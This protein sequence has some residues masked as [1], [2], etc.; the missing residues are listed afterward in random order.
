MKENNL[1]I[2]FMGTP[3]FS[4]PILNGLIENYNVTLVVCQP[5]R[6]KNRKGEIIMPETKKIA[7]EHNIEV[8]QPE[9]I[10][11]DYQKILDKN[12]DIIITCA[13]G[14]IIP[15]IIINTPKYGAINV[16]GS[17]LPKLRG[18]APIHWAIING[19][20][21]TG[22]TIMKM[23]K[24]MDAGEI[25]SQKSL[26]I[27]EDETLDSLYERMSIL[28]NDL[29]QETIPDIINNK[30]KYTPQDE[31]KVT[32]GLNITKEDEKIDF[33][34]SKEEIKNLIRG[35][36]SNPGAYC[37]LDN[38]RL[39]IYEVSLIDKEVNNNYQN[40]QII[41]IEKDS[42]ICKCQ[43]GYLK[44]LDIALEGK[45][46]C[47]VKEYLNGIKKESLIGKVLK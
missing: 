5:D 10:K 1:K 37:Y 31:T 43:N 13:Y 18:G 15:E 30:V 9:H 35:L 29:L 36:C 19:E 22:I 6:K 17:L 42:I 21:E 32:F 45:K 41:E 2:V 20:K 33:S 8:F 23:S 28:G 14:Q 40:G 26:E 38:K 46:R 11:E 4:V 34:K 24:K 47:K 25:I 16:H 44:I 7:L 12:P 3:S 27:D 39:K